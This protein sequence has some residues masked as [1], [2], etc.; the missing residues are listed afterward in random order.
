MFPEGNQASL[1]SLWDDIELIH[2]VVV[3]LKLQLRVLMLFYVAG[4]MKISENLHALSP[5]DI[6]HWQ[7][8]L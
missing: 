6:L 8:K 3:T 1:P 7:P 4:G 2:H 5:A